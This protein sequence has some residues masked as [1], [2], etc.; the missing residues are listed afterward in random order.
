M[1][2]RCRNPRSKDFP[3]YGAVGITVCD[4]WAK[5]QAFLGDMGARP[6]LQHSIDRIDGAKGYEPSN[7]RWATA[8]EQTMN[9][10]VPKLDREAVRE[11][12]EDD[13]PYAEIAEEHG[14]SRAAVCMAR[15]G[16]T[17]KHA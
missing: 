9:S 12:R 6:S 15:S 7:C 17:W 13:R 10:A 5:F 11:I 4:R 16:K 2:Y 1:H 8:V 14:V 3:R